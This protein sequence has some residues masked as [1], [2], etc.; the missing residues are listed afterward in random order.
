MLLNFSGTNGLLVIWDKWEQMSGTNLR[1]K[2]ELSHYMHHGIY[3]QKF[4]KNRGT[5]MPRCAPDQI[6][7]GSDR[8]Q[9]IS[10]TSMRSILAVSSSE[11][12]WFV[13]GGA[14]PPPPRY[15][16]GVAFLGILFENL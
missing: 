8:I 9:A 3:Q 16:P 15:N 4:F 2:W 13:T 1:N 10:K 5:Y 6:D 14:S 12:A 11:N 7:L